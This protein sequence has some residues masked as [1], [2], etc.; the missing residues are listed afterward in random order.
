MARGMSVT[1]AKEVLGGIRNVF[2]TME[3]QS[4]YE[5]LLKDK[6]KD[7]DEL[8]EARNVLFR[9]LI[10]YYRKQGKTLRVKSPSELCPQCNG[11]GERGYKFE[12]IVAK[13]PFCRGAGKRDEVCRVC[14]GTKE[15]NN[16]PCKRCSGTGTFRQ[17]KCRSCRG[18]G[19]KLQV[20]GI[21]ESNKCPECQGSGKAQVAT[22]PLISP[23][24][25]KKA[26]E[27]LKL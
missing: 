13:C 5:S 9:D 19:D 27:K 2:N 1:E 26:K 8:T 11:T 10:L 15:I 14:K 21:L 12:T 22:N 20:I 23:E 7:F 3:I 6:K 16:K 24:I 4:A 17:V 18:T 25:G